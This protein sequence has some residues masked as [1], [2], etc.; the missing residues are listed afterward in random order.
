M[1]VSHIKSPDWEFEEKS[2]SPDR[3]MFSARNSGCADFCSVPYTIGLDG[4]SMVKRGFY[5]F[6]DI[7]GHFHSYASKDDYMEWLSARK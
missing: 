7:H 1:K 5:V 2:S 3:L 4:E 6:R